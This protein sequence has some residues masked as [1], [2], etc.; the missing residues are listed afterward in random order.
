MAFDDGEVLRGSL[1]RGLART[2][3]VERIDDRANGCVIEGFAARIR[4]C[5]ALARRGLRLRQSPHDRKRPL[6]AC[7]VVSGNL[8]GGIQRSPDAQDIVANLK[9]HAKCTA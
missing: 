6:T 8:S 2:E 7:D 9:G 3:F 5:D 1:I 4:L